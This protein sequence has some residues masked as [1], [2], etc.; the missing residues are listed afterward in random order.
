MK[1]KATYAAISGWVDV[2]AIEG[3]EGSDDPIHFIDQE[4]LNVFFSDLQYSLC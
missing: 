4:L 2:D 1:L 3:V